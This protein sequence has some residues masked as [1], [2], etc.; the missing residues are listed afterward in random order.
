MDLLR[1]NWDLKRVW[2]FDKRFHHGLFG[3]GS[4]IIGIGLM[5]HDLKDF[6]WIYDNE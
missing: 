4:F 6:P 1:I 2:V 3:F 5:I